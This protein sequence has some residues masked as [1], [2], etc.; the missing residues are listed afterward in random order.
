VLEMMRD[1]GCNLG[2]EQS[3]HVIMLDCN[4]TG[5]GLLTAVQLLAAMQQ[6]KRPLAELVSG[7]SLFPQKLWNITL[8]RR[9]DVM[10]DASI[11]NDVIAAEKRLAGVGRLNVR[12]SGTEPK[13]RVMVE[14]ED[15][16]LM[17]EIG[18]SLSDTIKKVVQEA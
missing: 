17:L 9:M 6:R 5:D 4:T 18:E 10:S 3:G 16:A 2:G 14:A 13:L 15:E 8:P 7:I 12:A 1:K 11:M